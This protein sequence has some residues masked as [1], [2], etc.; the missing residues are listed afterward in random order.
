MFEGHLP[1]L[2]PQH[3][4][5]LG[6][7]FQHDETADCLCQPELVRLGRLAWYRHRLVTSEVLPDTVPEDWC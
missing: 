5:P 1:G 7:R 6:C 3:H 4:L 2:P